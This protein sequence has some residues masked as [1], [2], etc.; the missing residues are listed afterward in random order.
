MGTGLFTPMETRR[1]IRGVLLRMVLPSFLAWL[2]WHLATTTPGVGALLM[3]GIAA[4][5][6][7]AVTRFDRRVAAGPGPAAVRLAD[8]LLGGGAV[9]GLILAGRA[10]GGFGAALL[11]PVVLA[12]VGA[13][14]RRL[15][16]EG[17]AVARIPA[18]MVLAWQQ[19]RADVLVALAAGVAVGTGIS[20]LGLTLGGLVAGLVI[21]APAMRQH[22]AARRQQQE[23]AAV[24]AALAGAFR[25]GASWTPVV[26]AALRAP[27]RSVRFTGETPSEITVPLPPS[28]T[29]A[30]QV[31]VE[32]E[33]A[34]RL[35]PWGL[36]VVRF[37]QGRD[38]SAVAT[39]VPPLPTRL[40]YDGRAA[41]DGTVVWLG[42]GLATRE[43][44]AA[45]GTR[46]IVNGSTFDLTWD[47]RVEPHG[48]AVGTTGSGKSQT[49][50]LVMVQLA[51]AGWNLLLLDP[52]KVEFSNWAGRPGVLGVTTELAAHVEALEQARAEQDRRYEAMTAA[53]VNHID[54]LDSADRPRRLLV[55]VDEAVELLAPAQGKTDA[56]KVAN[57]LKGRASE[58]VSSMLRLGRAAGVHVILAAQRADRAV[59]TGEAQNNL[60]FKVIQGRSEQIER[61]MIGLGDVIATPGIP[62]RAVARTLQVPQSEVQVAYLD[63]QRLD[64]HLPRGG[65]Q[66]N[67]VAPEHPVIDPPAALPS[68]VPVPRQV[69][70]AGGAG[71]DGTIQQQR[72]DGEAALQAVLPGLT[73]DQVG[74]YEDVKARLL[75]VVGTAFRDADAAAAY[76]IQTGG[77]LLY[78]PPGTGKTFLSEAL[79][80]SLGVAY[81]KVSVGDLSSQWVGEGAQKIKAAVDSA[82]AAAPCL[83]V[84]DE[85][86][87]IAGRR[88]DETS[89]EGRK[90]VN[91]LLVELDRLKAAPG[92]VVMATTNDLS[93]LDAAV[94]RDG[95]FDLR[96]RIDLPDEAARVG[97]LRASLASRPADPV[98]DVEA[99]AARAAGYSAANL[100]AV[101]NGAARSALAD[102]RLISTE[103]LLTAIAQRGGQDRP[104]V[105]QAGLDGLVLPEATER[106]LRQV[107]SLITDPDRARA[108]GVQPPTGLLLAGPP[109]TG[110]TSIAR[111]LAA[112]ARTSFYAIAPGDLTSKWQG[113]V[114]QRVREIYERARENAPSI[115]FIDEIDSFGGAR[116]GDDHSGGSRALLPLLAEMDGFGSGAA[117]GAVVF[118]IAATN[119]PDTLDPALVRPG[120]LSRTVTVGLPEEAGR[121]ALLERLTAGVPLGADVDVNLL[122]EVTDGMSPA[123]LGGLVQQA[124]LHALSTAEPGAEPSV[125]A[126][127]FVAVLQG[128]SAAA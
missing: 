19:R 64:D 126:A 28:F 94:I 105:E 119:R 72:L 8:I 110:K 29:A 76:G 22:P 42:E 61:T 7:I 59:L 127:S 122:A 20:M 63:L 9:V 34:D 32:S 17:S 38:R 90:G 47:L 81:L 40:A 26:E 18:A 66:P 104:T 115:V 91:A 70:S 125:D 44:A 54:L 98:L 83:L 27:V 69:V 68:V 11:V 106:D 48:L 82:L 3:P 51:K 73:L 12:I 97:I 67:P 116:G 99:V 55:V 77:V 49:V 24:E 124:T 43:H 4:A 92:V 30:K 75:D 58:A 39:L 16:A 60:A 112:E 37:T 100:S 52:K 15:I 35:A 128:R 85:I 103:D 1:G 21:V 62:G 84:I 45:P 10:P 33:I 25:G 86:D 56:A 65:V 79:A 102:R 107:L 13:A 2:A 117:G 123:D 109:G 36:Y 6:S 114:E 80:G 111:A 120:R 78:G 14:S 96:I 93:R 46:G 57:E 41:Q 88:D 113:Q 23:R 108:Y 31:D 101:V 87:A 89:G 5:L 95:R 50:Q 53:G 118:T 74:G 121:R 71:S